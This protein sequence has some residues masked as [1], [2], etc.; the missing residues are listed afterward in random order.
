MHLGAGSARVLRR[1]LAITIKRKKKLRSLSRNTR[2][3]I[4]EEINEVTS[5][6]L[7]CCAV[8]IPVDVI[9]KKKKKRMS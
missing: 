4:L 6:A 2:V 1:K 3:T 9:R 8:E 7:V 5:T